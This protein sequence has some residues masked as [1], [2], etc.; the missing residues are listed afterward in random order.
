MDEAKVK[1]LEPGDKTQVRKENL[2]NISKFLIR[3]PY[4]EWKLPNYNSHQ[5]SN[6]EERI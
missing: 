3:D 1:K 2:N 6:K 4:K 5:D